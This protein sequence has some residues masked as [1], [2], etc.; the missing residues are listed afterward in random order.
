[1]SLEEFENDLL[2]VQ[3]DIQSISH[4]LESKTKQRDRLIKTIQECCPH[5]N[6]SRVKEEGDDRYH[7]ECE[8]CGKWNCTNK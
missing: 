3:E 4:I 8:R 1:M 6:I 2:M 7:I 5:Q